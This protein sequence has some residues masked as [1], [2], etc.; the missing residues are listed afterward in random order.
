MTV[1]P[2][3]VRLADGSSDPDDPGLHLDLTREGDA[4][5]SLDEALAV[6]EDL[7]ALVHQLSDS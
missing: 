4:V 5:I 1:R 7:M 3:A 6:A 2:F